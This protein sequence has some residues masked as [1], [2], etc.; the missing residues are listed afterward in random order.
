MCKLSPVSGHPHPHR[1]LETSPAWALHSPLLPFSTRIVQWL[2]YLFC[3]NFVIAQPEVKTTHRHY[4][5]VFVLCPVTSVSVVS[6]C[7]CGRSVVVQGDVTQ[8]RVVRHVLLVRKVNGTLGIAATC[9]VTGRPRSRSWTKTSQCYSVGVF[10]PYAWL[11]H[12]YFTIIG[13]CWSEYQYLRTWTINIR[14]NKYLYSP[15]LEIVLCCTIEL[16]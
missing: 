3:L 11:G 2:L 4:P 8:V 9:R 15:E 10:S 12:Q 5:D 16:Q 14:V 7:H 6:Q 1:H 13:H